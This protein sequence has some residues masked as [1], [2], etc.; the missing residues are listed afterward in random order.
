MIKS[1]LKCFN[2]N[3]YTLIKISDFKF[4]VISQLYFVIEA[5]ELDNKNFYFDIKVKDNL[6][7]EPLKTLNY[8][9]SNF[10]LPFTTYFVKKEVDSFFKHSLLKILNKNNLN[11]IEK[12]STFFK[13]DFLKIRFKKDNFG[14][15][16]LNHIEYIYN[17]QKFD[18]FFLFE[19]ELF[20]NL[21]KNKDPIL[22]LFDFFY[23]NNIDFKII[24]NNKKFV[25]FFNNKNFKSSNKDEC[26]SF[27]INEFIKDESSNRLIKKHLESKEIIKS[28]EN[29]SFE[30]FNLYKIMNY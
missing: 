27:L 19:D 12:L 18:Q 9:H 17:I 6:F 14:I 3:D 21:S 13:T 29:L 22:K 7:S 5:K 10:C 2:K 23:F 20:E 1:L 15:L 24:K 8:E 26:I 25:S 4:I 28:Y 11:L 30:H 16:N